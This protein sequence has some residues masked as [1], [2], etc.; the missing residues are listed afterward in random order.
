MW[1][2]MLPEAA[3][4]REIRKSI[5][6]AAG[7][8][9]AF[10][11]VTLISGLILI[12]SISVI[13]T[14]ILEPA[15]SYLHK[16]RIPRQLS[17]ALL[18]LLAM[19]GLAL[20]IYL[21]MKPAIAQVN[22]IIE[23]PPATFERVLDTLRRW[24]AD[25]PDIS[26]RIPEHFDRNTIGKFIG[27]ILGGASRATASAA[28]VIGAAFLSLLLTVY[29]ISDPKPVT[30]GILMA[31][32]KQRRDKV[33]SVGCRLC[34]RVRSWARGVSLG[35]LFVFIVSLVGFSIVG[36][37]H[38]W[39]FAFIA[40]LMEAIPVVGPVMAAVP[41][42]VMALSQEPI[43]ALWVL[44]VVIGVQFVQNNL[45]M[46]LVYS[47][48]LSFH[49]ITVI[50]AVAIM[51][52][53]FGIPGVFLANPAASAAAIVYEEFYLKSETN[54]VTDEHNWAEPIPE[55]DGPDPEA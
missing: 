43:L 28:G 20:L 51:G 47:H 25:Y 39:L 17:A 5:L 49:P 12:L 53:L 10:R 50:L 9:L 23:Q 41:P 13:F 34:E 14:I 24:T 22:D 3:I 42:L 40:G 21:L 16:H 36:V 7:L 35:M 1:K 18:A 52:G 27:P 37:K 38:A 11:F 15:V 26:K 55:P 2:S 33:Q 31:F 32:G 6:F 45:I 4:G 54:P 19:A 30:N 29:L 46:P 8:Y 48:Q 44:L